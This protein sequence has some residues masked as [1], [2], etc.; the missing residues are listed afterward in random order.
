MTKVSDI[1]EYLN[2]L[3]PPSLAEDFDNVGLMTGNSLHSVKR[4]MVMLD[5]DSDTI[6]E[7][8][9]HNAD[10]I[11]THHPLIFSPLKNVT[12]K[13]I[14]TLIKN[15]IALFSAHTNLDSGPGGV[16]DNLAKLL[17]LTD[18]E[19]VTMPGINLT[20]VTGSV[21]LCTLGE[22]INTVKS[23]LAIDNIRYTGNL[24]DKISRV[25]VIGGSA[26]EFA[27]EMKALG[28]DAFLTADLKYHQAQ[29]AEEIGLNIVDAGHFETE[30]HICTVLCGLL[31]KQFPDIDV[32]VSQRKTSYIKFG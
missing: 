26:A 25:G 27:D 4:V 17:K 31:Q 3:F 1:T 20:G 14:T 2:S 15:D 5:A 19:R 28:C 6:Q 32:L 16:N 22:F 7:A 30:N 23:V 10:M 24:S 12:D 21:A 8:V 29:H 11:V 18:T 13:N 9:R